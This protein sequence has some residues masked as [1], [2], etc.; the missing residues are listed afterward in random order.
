MRCLKL[1]SLVINREVAFGE[2]PI[3]LG[4]TY[5]GSVYMD[6][7]G[8]ELNMK[9]QLATLEVVCTSAIIDIDDACNEVKLVKPTFTVATEFDMVCIRFPERYGCNSAFTL[10]VIN[11]VVSRNPD[12]VTNSASGVG[13]PLRSPIMEKFNQ[14]NNQY[15]WCL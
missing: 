3:F 13:S 6:L 15:R 7:E 12:G 8:V 4:R 5:Y 9:L 11:E 2:S 10:F 1:H 14:G